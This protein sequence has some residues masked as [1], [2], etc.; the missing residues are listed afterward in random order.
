MIRETK[1]SKERKRRRKQQ[2]KKVE[3]K[4]HKKEVDLKCTHTC[5][6]TRKKKKEQ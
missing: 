1:I 4:K 6:Y 5:I 2:I 3:L